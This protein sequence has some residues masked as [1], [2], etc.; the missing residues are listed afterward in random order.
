L[1]TPS[2]K[3]IAQAPNDSIYLQSLYDSSK[4]YYT[5]GNYTKAVENLQETLSLKKKSGVDYEPQYFKVYNRLG[6][7]YKKNG[8][9]KKAIDNY[10]LALEHTSVDFNKTIINGNIANVYSLLGEYSKA[11]S[12]LEN[13]LMILEKSTNKNKIEKIINNYHNQ[14]Y[15]Y[16]QSG[17]YGLALLKSLTSIQIAKENNYKIQGSTLLNCGLIY[18]AMDSLEKAGYYYKKSLDINL[19]KYGENN[20]HTGLSYMYYAINF[21]NKKKFNKSNDLLNKALLILK[22]NLGEKHL[23]ISLCLKHLGN[24][25]FQKQ[26]YSKSLSYYQQAL[27]AKIHEFNDSCIYKNPAKD[28]NP[29]LD[30]LDILNAKAKALEKLEGNKEK[31]LKAALQ[32]LQLS[33]GFIEQLRTG[34]LYES[35]KLQLAAKEYD[36]YVSIINLAY[37]L[38]KQ[39]KDS[40]YAETAFEYAELSKYAILR[41]LE[42]EE[43]AKEIAG[44]PKSLQ[45]N[46][47]AL[48]EQIVFLSIQAQNENELQNP[49]K[50]KIKEYQQKI[51]DVSKKLDSLNLELKTNYPVYYKQKYSHKIISKTQLQEA[52]SPKDAILEYILADSA[53]FTFTITKNH[54]IF[55]KQKTG[56]SFYNH[57]KYYT[58][59]LHSKHSS[60]YINYRNAA[61][62]LYKYLVEPSED[63]IKNKNLL[64]I[65]GNQ[66]GL[67]SF[68]ALIDKPYKEGD[69]GDYRKESYILNK[70]PIGYA[71]SATLYIQSKN[72]SKNSNPSFLGIAPSYIN[73]KD[74]LPHLPLAIKNIKKLSMLTCGK[75]LSNK[76]ATKDNFK[77]YAG[78]Y[79]IIHFYAHGFEDTL[80]PANSKI[81]LSPTDTTD[82][83]YL[84][85]WEISNM[86]LDA[87]LVI[88]ASC[89]SGS[90]KLSKGEGV[91]NIG[92][93]FAVANSKSTLIALWSATY[94]STV[95]ETNSFFMNLLKGKRKDEALRL[96]KLKYLEE[97]DPI[98]AHPRFWAS[99]IINGNQEALY[100]N[101]FLKK[102][103]LLFFLVVVIILFI[104]RKSIF[105]FS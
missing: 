45:R 92:R 37:A 12:Y 82:D 100:H 67:I 61:Y 42:N 13:S 63:F 102:I 96:A 11:I 83:G 52:I 70:Y 59:V 72:D 73:S 104:K 86:Q 65:P 7:V 53:L 68:E 30:L 77:K 88:L 23:Y 9:F 84:Y 25:H 50:E 80:N 98:N 44:V 81:S 76:K 14:G 87:Q 41:D 69:N 31:N 27:I 35:S 18:Q 21:L 91:L 46:E 6:L 105:K 32:T 22:N 28:V 94:E 36:T 38:Y 1:F 8:N 99:L 55:T 79:D 20:L 85:A 5:H 71:F 103:I 15:A 58:R 17:Q 51:F 40:S 64:I 56:S 97:T 74:S 3:L 66:M 78:N 62:S 19:R 95:F 90:G 57:L 10:T 48:K 54:F 16:Y 39:T 93:S 60:P 4:V 49:D 2:M 47:Q 29:D 34:Y 101:F 75:L 26:N 89:Y 33:V 43:K 24:L